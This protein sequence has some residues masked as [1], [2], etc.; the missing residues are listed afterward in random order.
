[1]AVS[2]K[3]LELQRYT[4]LLKEFTTL[5]E[6]NFPDVE[7]I[8]EDFVPIAPPT[9]PLFEGGYS[10]D[11]IEMVFDTIM[12]MSRARE[13]EKEA[14]LLEVIWEQLPFLQRVSFRGR[15]YNATQ[16]TLIE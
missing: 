3:L 11:R 15:Y 5:V 8:Y 6:V 7:Q 14:R 10:P 16:K 9:L 4:S 1:L 13:M 2:N 12:E